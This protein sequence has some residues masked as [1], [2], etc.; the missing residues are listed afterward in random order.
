MRSIDF[1]RNYIRLQKLPFLASFLENL[2]TLCSHTFSKF[3]NKFAQK[4]SK[5]SNKARY[6]RSL[7]TL[8]KISLSC[9][10]LFSSNISF[11]EI[12]LLDSARNLEHLNNNPLITKTIKKK[13]KPYLI[14]EN[15]PAKAILDQ[16]FSNSRVITNKETFTLAGFEILHYQ[17]YT[18]IFVASHPLLPGYLVKGY[19]DSELYIKDHKKGWE[20]LV[21]RCEGARNV[22][23]IIKEKNLKH[24]EAPHKYLYPLPANGASGSKQPII[25]IVDDMNLYSLE[26]AQSIWK[27]IY[28]REILKELSIILKNGYSSTYLPFNIPPTRTGKFA[29]ID[30]EHPKRK[31]KLKAVKQFLSSESAL[32]WDKLTKKN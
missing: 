20:W 16:I 17:P 10:L 29:C 22:R 2:S 8:L 12:S 31:L 27:S 7:I 5:F 21:S 15:H 32:Y 25:L 28:D 24:F 19:L 3:S 9:S 6:A 18:H 13:I 30:T 23:K 11:A 4:S 26:Q 14:R 1:L